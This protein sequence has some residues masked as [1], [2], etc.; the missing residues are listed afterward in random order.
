MVLD[1]PLEPLCLGISAG[2]RGEFDVGPITE[3]IIPDTLLI[4]EAGTG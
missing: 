3:R 2:H 1:V 4:H